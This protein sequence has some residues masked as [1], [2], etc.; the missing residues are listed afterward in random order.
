MAPILTLHTNHPILK[1]V[2]SIKINWHIILGVFFIWRCIRNIKAE[3]YIALWNIADAINTK[4]RGMVC[5]NI[6]STTSTLLNCQI[7]WTKLFLL[8]LKGKISLDN[9]KD[10]LIP[11][12][13]QVWSPVKRT[14]FT[15][16]LS[17]VC[18]S[19]YI[20]WHWLAIPWT[21]EQSAL[22]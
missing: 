1:K 3:Y 13:S 15:D 2:L 11:L 17:I 5:M 9:E 22:V 6:R 20:N 18:L 19:R 7:T 14:V 10:E 8:W 4:T 16:Q 12:N 21:T